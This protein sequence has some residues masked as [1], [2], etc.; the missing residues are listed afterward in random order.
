MT[1][2]TNAAEMQGL[3]P[4]YKR[5]PGQIDPQPVHIEIN[6]A[7]R[8][9]TAAYNPEIGDTVPVDVW[10]GVRLRIAGSRYMTGAD[11]VA[12]LNDAKVLSLAA[13]ICDGH[14]VYWDNGNRRGRLTEDAQL[15]YKEL[16]HRITYWGGCGPCPESDNFNV[17][18]PDEWIPS[19]DYTGITADTADAEITKLAAEY[20]ANAERDM[21]LIDGDMA[22]WLTE[23]RRRLRDEGQA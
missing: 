22:D 13:E 14:E 10:H 1:I 7:E 11:W 5:F 16:E 3:A 19:L 17:C 6:P 15:A 23:L 8:T 21:T 12:L 4:L 9:M 2:T 20:V 18:A